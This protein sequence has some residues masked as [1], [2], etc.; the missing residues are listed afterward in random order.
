MIRYIVWEKLSTG[1]KKN[2]GIIKGNTKRDLAFDLNKLR[3]IYG[4]ELTDIELEYLDGLGV[5]NKEIL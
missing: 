1:E 3:H 2:I 5:D 4:I